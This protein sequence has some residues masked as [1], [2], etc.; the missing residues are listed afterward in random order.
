L[1]ASPVG[2]PHTASTDVTKAQV[3]GDSPEDWR[4]ARTVEFVRRIAAALES[5]LAADRVPVVLAADAEI[6]GHFQKL[7]ALGPLLAGAVEV[8]PEALDGRALH[9]AAY[10]VVRPRFDED[11]KR[12]VERLAALLGSGDS[13]GTTGA[14]DVVRAAFAGRVD[15][16]LLA[17]GVGLRGRFDAAAGKVTVCEEFAVTGEDL[18]DAAA[19]QTL[20][21]G[22]SVYILPR[23]GMPDAALTAAA[24]RY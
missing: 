15:T 6:A 21:R 1:Q 10:A 7:T 4:K 14:E 12:A 17:E 8:N 5:H 3:H 16:L 9:A 13:R 2:R 19:V 24:P 20:G 18:L 11:R 23:E 22:G